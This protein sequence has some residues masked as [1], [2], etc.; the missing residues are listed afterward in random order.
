MI[1]QSARTGLTAASVS[2]PYAP[3]LFF[4]AWAIMGGAKWARLA[5]AIVIGLRMALA[6]YWMIVHFGGGLQWNAL[7]TVGIGIFVLW[8]LYG[9]DASERYFEGHP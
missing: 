7:L 2:E 6:V 1:L 9:N 5:V 3:S 4:V 8:A